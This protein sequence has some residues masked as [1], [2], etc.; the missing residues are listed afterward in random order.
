MHLILFI[1]F[2]FLFFLVGRG[3]VL[4]FQKTELRKIEI[5]SIKVFG[6]P[7][8]IFYTLF[9]FI[10]ISNLIFILNFFFPIKKVL[11]PIYLF[12]TLLVFL[13]LFN[14]PSFRNMKIKFYSFIIFPLFLSISSYGI[15]MGWDTGLYHLQSQAWI[16]ESNIVIGL[17][18]LN[19]WLGWSSIYEYLS[20][21]FWFENNYLYLHFLKIIIY[22]FFYVFL[23]YNILFNQI[24]YLKFSSLGILLFSLL[25][26]VGYLGGSNGFPTM[27][28]VGKFDEVLGIFL[29]TTSV[30]I[31]TCIYQ[32]SYKFNEMSILF[33]LSLFCFQLKQNGVTVIF[34]LLIYTYGYIKQNKINF[35][36]M[37]SKIK[38]QIF[39][40]LLWILKNF[41]IT[42]CF[43]YPV[44]FTC[45]N[46]VDWYAI[47]SNYAATGWLIKAP[48]EFSSSLSIS[49]QVIR[50]LDESK[51][52]QYAYNF[53][54]SIVIIFIANKLFLTKINTPYSFGTKQII[55]LGY[56]IFLLYF[57]FNSNGANPRYGFGI[58]L[59][60]VS[61]FYID[62]ERIRFKPFLLKYINLIST[63]TIILS[64]A[65]VP[66][67][68]SYIAF[69]E[70]PLVIAPIDLPWKSENP[71][72]A[73]RVET[74]YLKS[75]YGFGVYSTNGLCWNIHYCHHIDK[76]IIF[77]QEGFFSKFLI[78]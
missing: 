75:N 2:N 17:S 19:V 56:L 35:F 69:I 31:L 18:N 63:V 6:V 77:V 53:I 20:S 27:L 37:L 45:F 7:L 68:Y 4:I 34:L 30:L 51:Y 39:L 64:V 13:N 67:I 43:Y 3:I 21:I 50:W 44:S 9:S 10:F 59:I 29:F 55:S 70:N 65:L 42:S 74:E 15:W 71:S 72:F 76:K 11:V 62:H 40:G 26:N 47:D 22:N 12:L 38:L 73:G 14:F 60:T 46:F 5:D 58:W 66:R 16:R 8:Y 41:L 1:I 57:W 33:F 61:M 49:D 78:P 54:F 48:I 23:L 32:K 28:T 25:D 36:A 24:K 52:D